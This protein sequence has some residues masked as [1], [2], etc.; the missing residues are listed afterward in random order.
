MIKYGYIYFIETLNIKSQYALMNQE[1]HIH[2]YCA[3][4]DVKILGQFTD[5]SGNYKEQPRLKQLLS[6]IEKGECIICPTITQ[7]SWSH[8]TI[9]ST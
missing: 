7:L 6:I 8:E 5:Q 9:L 3:K 1:Y 2:I 4:N